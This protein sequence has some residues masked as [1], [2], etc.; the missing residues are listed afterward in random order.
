MI[1]NSCGLTLVV[2]EQPAKPFLTMDWTLT[3]LVGSSL[4]KGDHI[5]D[6]LMRTENENRKR[7]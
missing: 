4:R 3:I 1:K 7:P 5:A 6:S 2:F